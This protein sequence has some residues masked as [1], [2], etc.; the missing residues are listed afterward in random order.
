MIELGFWCWCWGFLLGRFR[1]VFFGSSLAYGCQLA[2]YW[3][4]ELNIMLLIYLRSSVVFDCR[5]HCYP[6]AESIRST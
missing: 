3:D 5:A 6:K 1:A 4:L 2:L